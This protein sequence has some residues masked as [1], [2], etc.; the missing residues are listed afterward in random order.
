M[1]ASIPLQEFSKLSVPWR[2]HNSLHLQYPPGLTTTRPPWNL[3]SKGSWCTQE[4]HAAYCTMSNWLSKSI[5]AL[6]LLSNWIYV[7]VESW[8][9]NYQLLLWGCLEVP[10]ASAPLP[11][12]SLLCLVLNLASKNNTPHL[13]CF[14]LQ[15]LLQVLLLLVWLTPFL[16]RPKEEES[17]SLLLDLEH[18]TIHYWIQISV[19][20]LQEAICS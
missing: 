11:F 6:C 20:R 14:W 12:S 18:N 4:A 16:L 19:T 15:L 10:P 17:V 5:W 3:E 7:I 1:L 2:W 9:N 8:P 13:P